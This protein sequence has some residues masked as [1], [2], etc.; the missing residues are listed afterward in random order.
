[1][2]HATEDGAWD[3][4]PVIDLIYSLS[5]GRKETTINNVPE[6][7]DRE[8]PTTPADPPESDFQCQLGNFDKI[9]TYLG[10]PLDV[11]PPL[12]VPLLE[13][14]ATIIPGEDS[15]VESTAGKGVRW[16][17][18]VEGAGLEDNDAIGDAYRN[19]KRNKSQRKKE[20]KKASLERRDQTRDRP[21]TDDN[22]S[23]SDTQTSRQPPDRRA[24]I[25]Q[26]LYG[27]SDITCDRTLTDSQPIATASPESLRTAT[28]QADLAAP[29][30][31]S[32]LSVRSAQFVPSWEQQALQIAAIKKAQ[33]VAILH[34]RFVDERQYMSNVSV[35]HHVMTTDKCNMNGIHVFVDASN[36][37]SFTCT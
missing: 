18:E 9:W 23:E 32:K 1:M 27:K 13:T 7:Q 19:A 37:R 31:H 17:D 30:L 20:R 33:L 16:R 25:Q 4:T 12:V 29:K 14:D 21:E 22:G 11:P 24:V 35:V 28:G 3:L 2:R 6:R 10:Q 8:L 26:I 15:N 5:L 36:V 34:A